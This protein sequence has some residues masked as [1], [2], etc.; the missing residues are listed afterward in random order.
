VISTITSPC[1]RLEALTGDSEIWKIRR[2]GFTHH[3]CKTIQMMIPMWSQFRGV[4]A[5]SRSIVRTFPDLG[6]L[7]LVPGATGKDN[8]GC[9]LR[10]NLEISGRN[11]V[12]ETGVAVPSSPSRQRGLT[13][14]GAGAQD[15]QDKCHGPPPR[16]PTKSPTAPAPR[17]RCVKVPTL[18]SWSKEIM[19]L[20]LLDGC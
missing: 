6:F 3:P 20:F 11:S 16:G 10:Y 9:H 7:R 2:S 4:S 1:T 8:S 15:K 19:L 5:F 14:I 12:G 13:K 18:R 17:L